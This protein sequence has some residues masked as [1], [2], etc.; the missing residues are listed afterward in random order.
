MIRHA[1]DRRHAD[2]S[3]LNLAEVLEQQGDDATAFRWLKEIEETNVLP[4][5]AQRLA[6]IQQRQPA[7]R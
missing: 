2:N 7:L 4:T 6:R 3:R 1:P 5:A